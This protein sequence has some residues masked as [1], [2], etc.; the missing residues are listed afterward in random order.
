[1]PAPVRNCYWITEVGRAIEEELEPGGDWFVPEHYF[2]EVLSILRRLVR[3]GELTQAKADAAVARLTVADVNKVQL[4]P[5]VPDV[6]EL[7]HNVSAYDAP[8]VI[9][10]RGLGAKLVSTDFKL[11]GAPGLGVE[12][13][14]KTLPRK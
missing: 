13:V 9:I 8:Y 6:W 4:Q 10:A 12:F 5:L 2:I 11:R 1:M 14:P 3:A 7:R